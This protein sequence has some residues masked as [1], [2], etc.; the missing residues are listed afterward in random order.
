MAFTY[1][2]NQNR[3]GI[4]P[5]PYLVKE[6]CESNR[7]TGNKTTYVY[8]GSF[9]EI[10]SQRTTDMFG[11]A[12]TTDVSEKGDGN[13][14]LTSVF[15]YDVT[16][17]A[18]AATS[19]QLPTTS[20]LPGNIYDLEISME[21]VSAY[22]SPKLYASLL[23][24]FG[25]AD[26]S[27]K[28]AIAAVQTAVAFFHSPGQ[29]GVNEDGTTPVAKAQAEAMLAAVYPSNA[30]AQAL[31]LS[32]FHN[33]AL[34]GVEVVP[35][36][37]SVFKRTITA[38]SPAQVQASRAGESMIWTS[39][40]VALFENLPALWWFG[41]PAGQQWLKTPVNVNLVAGGKTRIDYSYISFA[42]ASGLFFTAYNSAVLLP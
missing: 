26:A 21:T 6:R 31:M 25:G 37:N 39:V 20:E 9:T 15:N 28:N 2:P 22:N 4:G 27:V 3:V 14:T 1:P 11:G 42:Q 10:M 35:Q 13:Y 33:V 38:A 7:H 41:L 16:G 32:L 34:M 29:Y 36:Y 8:E 40:E 18:S 30:T 24:A 23:A 12:Q 17:V 5:G 19:A